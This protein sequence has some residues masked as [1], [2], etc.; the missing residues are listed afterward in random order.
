MKNHF[1]SS[2]SSASLPRKEST[3]KIGIHLNAHPCPIEERLSLMKKHGF[4]T[5]FCFSTNTNL[6]EVMALCKQYDITVENYHAPFS[7]VQDMWLDLPE[8]D[9]ML[10]ELMEAVDSTSDSALIR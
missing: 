6:E 1:L 8:G 3:M 2:A 10:A 9:Q 5:T 4:D 7:H